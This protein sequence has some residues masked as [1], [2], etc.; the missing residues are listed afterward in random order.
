M[1][2]G[3]NWTNTVFFHFANQLCFKKLY[4]RN[5]SVSY[6]IMPKWLVQL[7]FYPCANFSFIIRLSFM[8]LKNECMNP[9]NN[10]FY[11]KKRLFFKTWLIFRKLFPP[12]ISNSSKNGTLL[13]T[14]CKN[15]FIKSCITGNNSILRQILKVV[16]QAK[17][18][19][20]KFLE[21]TQLFASHAYIY[22]NLFS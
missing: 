4:P 16:V 20:K 13:L 9:V 18:M 2:H 14:K 7:N 15:D 1:L 17:S 22:M 11:W 10:R 5:A 3:C 12:L 6:D 21:C 19:K 8:G